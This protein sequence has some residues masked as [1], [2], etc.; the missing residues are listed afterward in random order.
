[1]TEAERKQEQRRADKIYSICVKSFL[2]RMALV[3]YK[4][5]TGGSKNGSIALQVL[6]RK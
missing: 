3:R 4:Q 6:P 2:K 5:E 1:M